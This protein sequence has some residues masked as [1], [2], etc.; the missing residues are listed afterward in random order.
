MGPG[1]D[2]INAGGMKIGTEA[3]AQPGKRD[4]L[5][6]WCCAPEGGEVNEPRIFYA[7][8]DGPDDVEARSG[9][10]NPARVDT[11]VCRLEPNEAGRRCRRAV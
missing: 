3:D 5:C 6:A 1:H 8:R 11:P 2:R 9:R 10:S 4:R 7:A